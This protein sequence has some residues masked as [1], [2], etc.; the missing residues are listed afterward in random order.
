MVGL[1]EPR[2]A[3]ASV[4]APEH[5]V[6]VD[7]PNQWPS[8]ELSLAM[9]L[10]GRNRHCR[11]RDIRRRHFTGT[12]KL[13]VYADSAEPNVQQVIERTPAAI[14]QVSAEPPPKINQ[15]AVGAILGGVE[16]A[17]Q[18]PQSMSVLPGHLVDQHPPEDY[19]HQA[20]AEPRLLHCIRQESA[21]NGAA[22]GAGPTPNAQAKGL[23]RHPHWREA[24]PPPAT[25]PPK[26]QGSADRG[27]AES[28]R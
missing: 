2:V 14:V 10:P 13:V 12:V 7:D 3:P 1:V 25:R 17:A 5:P 18:S 19:S 28:L 26:G 15:K 9:A 20:M 8:H 24:R 27:A 11:V 22:E 23:T 4:E 21:P 16:E 6:L